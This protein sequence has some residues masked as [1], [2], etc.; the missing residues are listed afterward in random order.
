MD[1]SLVYFPTAVAIGAMHALE[2]GH[3]KTLTAAYL[4]GVKGTKRD[5]LLLGLCVAATH[6]IIVV[7]LAAAAVWVGQEAFTDEATWWLKIG[8]SVAVIGL[9]GWMLWKRWPRRRRD[10]AATD[11][12]EHDH[13]H[14]HLHDH[15]HDHDHDAM[16]EDEHVRA[17]MAT[18]PDYVA[19]GE[20]PTALQIMA[21]GA[22]GGMVPCPAAV[23]VMLLA[24]SVSASTSGLILVLG[25]SIG[26]AITL[27]GVGL[28]VVMGLSKVAHTGR[29]ATFSRHAPLIGA[30]LVVASG[31]FALILAGTI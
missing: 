19:R 12:S 9:G 18:M 29:L 3:A 5:A 28:A 16:D 13:H 11:Q 14:D 22:A 8:S 1:L 6:S 23:S 27:V 24:L 21:F 31:V 25:F 26:L 17:H 10:N 7:S 30:A 2:P 15:D 4:I 20:R